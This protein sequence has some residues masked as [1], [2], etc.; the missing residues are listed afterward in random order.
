MARPTLFAT[1]LSHFARK[2]RVVLAELDVDFELRFVPDLLSKEPADFGGNPI[3]RIPTLVHGERWVIE[4]DQIVRY[5]VETWDPGDRLGC[6]GLAPEQ[7]NVLSILNAC[8][9]AE[10]E[11]IL[12]AR[13][14]IPDVQSI[15][16][17]QRYAAVLEHCLRWLEEQGR[18]CWT[19]AEFSYLDVT[20]IACWEH[21]THYD[22]VPDMKRF[23]WLADRVARHAERATVAPSSPRFVTD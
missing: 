2:V 10:V 18:D 13:S 8:M 12:S 5:I 4:S 17:F 14:G 9:G 3:L 23:A 21:L 7:R 22:L 11:L 19:S 15:P 6:L 16:Y 1:P 20:L